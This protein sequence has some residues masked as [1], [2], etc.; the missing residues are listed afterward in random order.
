[1]A[2]R[3]IKACAPPRCSLTWPQAIRAIYIC[4]NWTDA[5]PTPDDS[6]ID[7]ANQGFNV[8]LLTFLLVTGPDGI[9]DTWGML[10]SATRAAAVSYV[11]SKGAIV[12]VSA[13]GA[14]ELPYDQD[15]V[16]YG[17]TAAAWALSNGLDGVD[18][19]LENFDWGAL[20]CTPNPSLH[21]S[22]AS[23]QWALCRF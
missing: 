10:D 9:L 5:G 4:G 19:D 20:A 22:C 13:G 18:F 23:L 14:T 12:L 21:V 2:G 1:M 8:I 16:E 6:V 11:H 3:E 17:R 7:A 15:P